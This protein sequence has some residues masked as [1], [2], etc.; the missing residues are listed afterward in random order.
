MSKVSIIGCGNM[1][2]AIALSIHSKGYEVKIYSPEIKSEV[3][4]HFA[5][6]TLK[7]ALEETDI[8]L[9]AVKPQVLP[10]L[11]DTLAAYSN[12]AFISIAAGVP[13]EVLERKIGAKNIARFMP[14]LAAS[15]SMSVTAVAY[16]ESADEEFRNQAME[17]ARTFGSAFILDEHLFPAFIGI[18]GSA[19]AFCLEMVHAIALGGTSAGIPY[20]KAADIAARTLASAAAVL[21]LTEE[22]RNPAELMTRV[23]SAGGTTIKG[24]EELY[25]GDFDNTVINAVLASCTKSIELEKSAKENL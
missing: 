6:P 13:L 19:I 23:C 10:S 3:L 25:K 12:H 2:S 9:L 8:V 1:G 11:Y 16:S 18:S 21:T 17:I 5:V 22:E 7:E 14:N 4:Q 24:M 15:E 20:P